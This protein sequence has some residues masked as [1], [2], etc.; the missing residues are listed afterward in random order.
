MMQSMQCRSLHRLGLLSSIDGARGLQITCAYVLAFFEQELNQAP[1][2]LLRRP[3][4]A[5]P[6]VHVWTP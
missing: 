3:S 1:S 4:S 6:E 5:Y 2:P